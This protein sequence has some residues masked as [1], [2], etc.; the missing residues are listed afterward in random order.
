MLHERPLLVHGQSPLFAA[1]RDQAAVWD[2]DQEK[3]LPR[4]VGTF[5]EKWSDP[6]HKLDPFAGCSRLSLSSTDGGTSAQPSRPTSRPT[7]LPSTAAREEVQLQTHFIIHFCICNLHLV[8]LKLI[9]LECSW[10][11]KCDPR[12]FQITGI[13]KDL[14][15]GIFSLAEVE[16]EGEERKHNGAANGTKPKDKIDQDRRKTRSSS[17]NTAGK[18]IK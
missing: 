18:K 11:W 16:K 14:E 3:Q 17:S 15:H 5:L 8:S 7:L 10:M 12:N 13:G 2:L 6:Q 4:Q 1:E 9:W